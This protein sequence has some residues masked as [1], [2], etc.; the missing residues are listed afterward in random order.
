VHYPRLRQRVVFQICTETSPVE[1][2]TL[3]APIEP[4]QSHTQCQ[5][6]KALQQPHI[7][8]DTVILIMTSELSLQNRPPLFCL[9]VIAYLSKPVV[10]LFAFHTEFLTAGLTTN[11]KL[12]LATCV[13]VMGKAKKVKGVGPTILSMVSMNSGKSKRHPRRF[14]I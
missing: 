6:I 12:T 14:T 5:R 2:L 13:A 3:T 8:A 4:F 7:T 9:L 10:H 1:R 11:Y